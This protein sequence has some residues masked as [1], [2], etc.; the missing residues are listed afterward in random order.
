MLI[1]KKITAA[2]CATIIVGIPSVS[3]AQQVPGTIEAESYDAQS[4]TRTLTTSDSGGSGF[5][6]HIEDGDYSEYIIDVPTAGTYRID[7]R[8]AGRDNTA[9]ITYSVNGEANTTMT[10]TPTGDWDVWKTISGTMTL[11][12]GTQLLRLDYTGDGNGLMNINWFSLQ[13]A[14]GSTPEPVDEPLDDKELDTSNWIL[15]ANANSGDAHFANDGN[16]NTRWSTNARQARGQEFYID[17]RT[18][19]EFDRIVLDTRQSSND[20]PREYIADVSI[21]GVNWFPAAVGEGNSNGDTVI[22]FSDQNVQYIRIRQRGSSDRFYWSIHE[23]SVFVD[24]SDLLI[25]DPPEGFEDDED[26]VEPIPD[27]DTDGLHPDI[28]RVIDVVGRN[29]GGVGWH[30][31]YSVGSKCY[32]SSTF[33]HAIGDVSVNTPVGQITVRELADLMGPGPGR[34]GNPIYNDVQCGNGPFN[35][36]GDEDDCPGRV[37]IGRDGCGQIGPLWDLSDL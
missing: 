23:L 16:S 20:Y 21:D 25:F 8:V 18:S 34:Q 6:G 3:L 1:P 22:D 10:V 13:P 26:D 32:I 31:S 7:A 37:D 27:D 28:V 14:D 9:T 15:S 11:G 17:M 19:R 12:A 2:I 5:V 30:D 33:D 29:P 36:A 4:G 24:S 35:D